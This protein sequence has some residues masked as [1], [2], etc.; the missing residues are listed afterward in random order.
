MTSGYGWA[1]LETMLALLGVCLLAVVS[2][3][4]LA[5]RGIGVGPKGSEMA[6][7]DRVPLDARRQLVLTEVRGRVFLLG[8]GDTGAPTLLAE[9][10][11]GKGAGF[12]GA[13]AQASASATESTDRRRYVD[14][15]SA[16]RRSTD[17][18]SEAR[19]GD[20]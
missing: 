4:W 9:L 19:N 17:A 15:D 5:K 6:V 18:G 16:D 14:Q 20:A 7:L 13:L 3:K 2:L 1:V 12:R 10:E 8:L 11:P